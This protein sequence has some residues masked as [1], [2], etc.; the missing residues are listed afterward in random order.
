MTYQVLQILFGIDLLHKFD[1][2]TIQQLSSGLHLS[3]SL[4]GFILNGNVNNSEL[5]NFEHNLNNTVIVSTV[6]IEENNNDDEQLNQLMNKQIQLEQ[7]NI[8]KKE[9][10]IL[11]KF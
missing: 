5:F 3:Q 11:Q 2:Q 7:W 6:V 9:Q 8:D 10:Q 4:I 1:I